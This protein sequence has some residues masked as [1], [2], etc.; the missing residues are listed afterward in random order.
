MAA[1][2]NRA[3][4]IR[5]LF[6]AYLANDRAAVEA[7]FAEDFRFTSPYDEG[8]DKKTYFS[9]C[10]RDTDWIGRHEIERILVDGAEAF[11]TYRC[12]GKDGKSFRNTEFFAFDGDKI[13]R[14][15]VYFGPSYEGGAFVKQQR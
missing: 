8:L 1:T 12:V 11:V 14:I 9:I 5:A 6:A 4:I 3:E 2:G 15:D 7:A 13:A 10:W